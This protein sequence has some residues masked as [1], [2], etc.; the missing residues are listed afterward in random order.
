MTASFNIIANKY[1]KS[2]ILH[3]GVES[4]KSVAAQILVPV[5]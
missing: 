3:S 1:N 2:N 5:H 4:K